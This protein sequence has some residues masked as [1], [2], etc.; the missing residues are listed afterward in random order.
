[1]GHCLL[2]FETN[3]VANAQ[4]HHFGLL[5][6]QCR[7]S[8]SCKECGRNQIIHDSMMTH[9][10]FIPPNNRNSCDSH[11]SGRNWVAPL[12]YAPF[13]LHE[14]RLESQRNI[15]KEIRRRFNIDTGNKGLVAQW[16]LNTSNGANNWIW[17]YYLL[18]KIYFT[19]GPYGPTGPMKHWKALCDIHSNLTLPTR[20]DALQQDQKR[21]QMH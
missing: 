19:D 2:C 17:I 4:F 5:S 13:L 9:S 12:I 1:V 7:G 10:H 20:S 14:S 6:E 21:L 8:S 11:A 16:S 3:H 15:A 18:K